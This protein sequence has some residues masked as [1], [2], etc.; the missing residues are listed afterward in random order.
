MSKN[1][2]YGPIT[3]DPG[4]RSEGEELENLKDEQSA[5]ASA[6]ARAD[7]NPVWTLVEILSQRYCRKT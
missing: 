5:S 6:R 3:Q 2:K 4:P 1:T 7:E